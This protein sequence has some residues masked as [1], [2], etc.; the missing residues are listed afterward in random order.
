MGKSR[1][2]SPVSAQVK[3]SIVAELVRRGDALGIGKSSYAALVFEWWEA[4][5]FPAVTQPDKLMQAA[6]KMGDD[7]EKRKAS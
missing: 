1:I 6:K 5:G 4:Q 2:A 3:N 7:G